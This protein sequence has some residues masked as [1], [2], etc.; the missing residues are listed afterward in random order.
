MECLGACVMVSIPASDS[1]DRREDSNTSTELQTSWHRGSTMWRPLLF[2]VALCPATQRPATHPLRKWPFL[3]SSAQFTWLTGMGP[4]LWC[5]PVTF[6]QT[7]CCA[8]SA[9]R[10]GGLRCS[11]KHRSQNYNEKTVEEKRRETVVFR[12]GGWQ[13][14]SICPL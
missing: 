12:E 10:A 4:P 9:C 6:S 8:A 7:T 13:D 1:V 5:R 2:L 14:V 11:D 3:H